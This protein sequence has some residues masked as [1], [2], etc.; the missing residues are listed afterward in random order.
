MSDIRLF[1]DLRGLTGGLRRSSLKI[2]VSTYIEFMGLSASLFDEAHRN[3][4]FLRRYDISKVNRYN[5]RESVN[6]KW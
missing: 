2:L 6:T 1:P 4:V 5:F 3:G